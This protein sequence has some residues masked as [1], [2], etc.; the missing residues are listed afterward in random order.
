MAAP[1]RPSLYCASFADVAQL[2][3]ASACHAEGRG[4]ESHHPLRVKAPETGLFSFLGGLQ[5]GRYPL[6]MALHSRRDSNESTLRAAGLTLKRK[7]GA[8]IVFVGDKGAKVMR[9]LA[10]ESPAEGAP[11]EDATGETAGDETPDADRPGRP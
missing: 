2:A 3:R 7:D 10:G 8:T 1:A 9:D 6:L 5:L 11:P 4:F